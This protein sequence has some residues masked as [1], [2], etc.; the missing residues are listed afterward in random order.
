MGHDKDTGAAMREMRV[1]GGG[2]ARSPFL[3]IALIAV[4]GL[5][6]YG[7][8]FQGDFQFDDIDNIAENPLVRDFSFSLFP[9]AARTFPGYDMFRSRRV[10]YLTFALNY[11]AH[12][13]DVTGYHGTNLL[14]HITNSLLVYALVILTFKTPALSRSMH[15]RNVRLI[16]LM[17]SAL[18]V[19][20]PVQTQ[21]V[22]YIVQRLASLACMFSLASL[23]FYIRFRLSGVPVVRLM[24]YVLCV[25]AAVLAM[26]TKETAF[27]LPLVIIL[28]EF[29][30]FRG[31]AARRLVHLAPVALTLVIIPLTLLETGSSLQDLFRSAGEETRLETGMERTTYLVTQFR[32]M[33]T[34]LRLLLLPVNQNVDYDYPLYDS[35]FHVHVLASCMV[36]AGLLAFGVYA[37]RRSG[38][39]DAS[40]RLVGFGVFWFFITLSVESSI[41]PIRDVIFEHRL[42][43]PAA[44]LFMALGTGAFSVVAAMEGAKKRS[45]VVCLLAALPV[46]FGVTTY[47]RN[48]VWET[49]VSLWEDGQ[50]KSPLKAR[51]HNNLAVGY[52][53]SGS[54]GRAI[55]HYRVALE[56]KPDYAE[57]HNNLGVAYESRGD[58][59]GAIGHYEA[60]VRLRPAFAAAHNNLGNAYTTRGLTE[61]AL[62]HYRIA[63]SLHPTFPDFRYNLALFLHRSGSTDEALPHYRAAL[64]AKPH[65]PEVH[66]S[67][68]IVYKEKG[69]YDRAMGHYRMALRQ[70]PS[71]AE[72]HVN[73]ANIHFFLGQFDEAIEHYR[74]ALELDPENAA[75]R[76]NLDIAV[77]KRNQRTA[78]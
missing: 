50:S 42:Y 59:D 19:A 49:A 75:A 1:A 39:R 16:A 22:T 61:K 51:V 55:E 47:T 10:G 52:R 35:L 14:I 3:H 13:L 43:L 74:T 66:N 68:G 78:P 23:I 60:A 67:L 72:A 57:A 20:H 12:G 76:F 6:A 62:A 46:L 70:D 32:V 11:K 30:F 38:K 56:L 65:F 25:V 53:K 58:V 48:A 69:M 27:T 21:A 7:N 4:L 26:K 77:Q 40:L 33:V 64:S 44:G 63:V 31:N 28:Y 5:L 37:L 15:Q 36:L 29:L 18:F 34:Y 54:T 2:F 41:I 73:L 24:H 8:T 17:A 45:A 71:Y 9:S